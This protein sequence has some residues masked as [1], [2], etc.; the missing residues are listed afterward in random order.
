MTDYKPDPSQATV[1]PFA[2]GAHNWDMAYDD[3]HLPRGVVGGDFDDQEP[4]A[5]ADGPSDFGKEADYGS[6]HVD[7]GPPGDY[8][9]SRSVPDME[10]GHVIPDRPTDINI[11]S[12]PD[13]ESMI[14]D[15]VQQLA[16]GG[17]VQVNQDEGEIVR[18]EAKK[19]QA[20]HEAFK[21]SPTQVW[22][23]RDELEQKGHNA[24]SHTID[25]YAKSMPKSASDA[26]ESLVNEEINPIDVM[27]VLTQRFGPEWYD[28]EYETILEECHRA[29]ADVPGINQSKIG[30]L[31]V[32]KNTEKFWSAPKVFEKVCLSFAS[33]VVDFFSI[34][35][36]RMHE[37]A[38]TIALV[39]RY[40]AENDFSDAVKNYV[41]AAAVR[42]GFILLPP[43]LQFANLAFSRQLVSTM[44]DEAMDR[45]SRLMSALEDE[46]PE[47]LTPEDVI[48]YMRMTRCE[49]HVHSKIN[50]LRR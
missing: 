15:R 30:A 48:Q 36:P 38:A 9:P 2:G 8:S 5:S 42:D 13:T 32:L 21:S 14:A 50:E 22:V 44:G 47:A 41:A 23:D 7:D 37:I 45:Q 24:S 6:M 33:R 17:E 16:R 49:Q 19:T 20:E 4:I 10:E 27:V 29:G 28:W 34:Q 18:E 39:D 12:A 35:E 40:L 3:P 26:I 1:G 43:S 31:K 25:S 46:D 11:H